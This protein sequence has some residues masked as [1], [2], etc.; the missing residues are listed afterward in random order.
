MSLFL[1]KKGIVMGIANQYS[2]ATAL[3]QFL[4]QEGASLGFSHLPDVD[5]R[6]K[7]K[8]RLLKVVESWNPPVIEPCNAGS[9]DDIQKFFDVVG[10]KMGSLDFL[11]HSIAFAPLEDIKGPTLMA[12]REGF[13]A[14]MDISAYSLIATAK[15]ARPLMKSGGSM[16]TISY[17]GGEKVVAGYNMMGICKAALEATVRYLA[18]D[19]GPD[20]IRVNALSAGP[21]KTAAASAI[22]DF[23]EMLG[24][25]EAIAPLGRN[26]TKEEVARSGGYL[27]SDL[28]SGVTGET[29]HVD[30]GF[31]AMA[32]LGRA[33]EKWN[34]NP[35][36]R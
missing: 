19:L 30:G 27:L 8:Q 2:I 9:D 7:M 22:G 18:Y 34:Y 25:N 3:S 6:G 11:V 13:K 24:M 20:N 23:N 10:E 36:K 5:D 28:S 15:A 21:L 33:L 17:F 16:L 35:W 26:V 1:G 14:A 32:G 4:I 29:H 31:H 12:S